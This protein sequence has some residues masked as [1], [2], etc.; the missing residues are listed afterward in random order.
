MSARTRW[1]RRL[2]RPRALLELSRNKELLSL[3]KLHALPVGDATLEL[4]LLEV[5]E[6]PVADATLL[7]LLLGRTPSGPGCERHR[8]LLILLSIILLSAVVMLELLVMLLALLSLLVMLLELLSLR[9]RS[10]AQ[11]RIRSRQP[12]CLQ[13]LHRQHSPG[14]AWQPLLRAARAKAKLPQQ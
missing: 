2:Q 5:M 3:Q 10:L 6:L 14:A 9:F 12:Q 4:S 7:S 1:R 13:R 8:Q 11:F